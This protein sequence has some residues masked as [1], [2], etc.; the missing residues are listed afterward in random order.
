MSKDYRLL[1]F[2]EFPKQAG[3]PKL[4]LFCHNKREQQQMGMSDGQMNEGRSKRQSDW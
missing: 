3:K 4:S 2:T 1:S